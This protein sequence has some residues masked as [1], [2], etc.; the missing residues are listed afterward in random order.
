MVREST[1]GVS[2]LAT[3][4]R[5]RERASAP[6]SSERGAGA[7]A[8]YSPVRRDQMRLKLSPSSASTSEA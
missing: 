7:D 1:S 5:Y 4:D 8:D 6:L 3:P 2:R